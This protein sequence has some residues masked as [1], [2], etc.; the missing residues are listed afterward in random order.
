MPTFIPVQPRL[1]AI[2][3]ADA[4][5]E[6]TIAG[7]SHPLIAA[8][9]TQLRSGIIARCAAIGRQIGRP[10]RL[11]VT[12]VNDSYQL[13]IHP[14]AFVQVLNP[15][16]TIDDVLQ[17]APRNIAES[18]CRQCWRPQP[19]NNR[20]C[21]MCGIK[22]PHDACIPPQHPLDY[23]QVSA[24]PATGRNQESTGSP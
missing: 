17:N 7:T 5:G 21:T 22:N 6:L 20:Y 23:P 12:D 11:T 9:T 15:D 1:A 13:A 18:P 10:V 19:L 2:V 16:G 3:R 24:A 8:G 14:D 4:S